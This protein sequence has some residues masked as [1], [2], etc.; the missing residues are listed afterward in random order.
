[1]HLLRDG[2]AGGDE[3]ST[4]GFDELALVLVVNADDLELVDPSDLRGHQPDPTTGPIDQQRLA[5]FKL[6]LVSAGVGARPSD[7]DRGGVGERDL[8]RLEHGTLCHQQGVLGI[9]ADAGDHQAEHLI[10]DREALHIVS[11]GGD[12]PGGLLAQGCR[13]L[14]RGSGNP[15]TDLPIKWVDPGRVDLDPEFSRGRLGV[16]RVISSWLSG[17]PYSL[18]T[19]T[20]DIVCFLSS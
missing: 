20:F 11:N 2:V 14:S 15:G 9:S 19:Y 8:L 18:N 7:R 16:L 1:M 6:D 12:D 17:P 5:W 10:A 3:D 4:G 13:K